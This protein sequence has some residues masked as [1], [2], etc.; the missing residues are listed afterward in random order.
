[1]T[2]KHEGDYDYSVAPR[3][4]H[5]RKAMPPMPTDDVRRRVAA[6]LG[7]SDDAVRVERRTTSFGPSYVLY[8]KAD[9]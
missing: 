2:S 8:V 3:G 5:A 7:V 9:V 1:M 6:S 4:F